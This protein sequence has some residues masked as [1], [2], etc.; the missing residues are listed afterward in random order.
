MTR[1]VCAKMYWPL[2]AGI[3]TRVVPSEGWMY[4]ANSPAAFASEVFGV[5][6]L[7]CR[8]AASLEAVVRGLGMC[9][10][11]SIVGVPVWDPV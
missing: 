5:P 11:E 9:V 10:A 1:G 4:P 2:P 7:P 6:L 3:K 8:W